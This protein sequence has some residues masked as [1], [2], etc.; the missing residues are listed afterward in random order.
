MIGAPPSPTLSSVS[1]SPQAGGFVSWHPGQVKPTSELQAASKPAS[2]NGRWSQL[3]ASEGLCAL[4]IA[5][6]VFLQAPWVRLS[7]FSA[8]AFTG[9]LVVAGLILERSAQQER[10]RIGSLLVG[11]S[12]SWLAGAI[13]WG[14]LRQH[15]LLHL[16]VEAFALPLALAGSS[17]RWRLACGFYLGSLLGTAATDLAIAATGLMP[18]WPQVLEAGRA[19]AALLLHQ[20]GLRVLEPMGLVMVAAMAVALVQLSRW[21]RRR[22]E[23]GRVAGT[24]LLT[25]LAVDG[26][27]LLAVL[28]APR[29]SGLI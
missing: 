21:L 10:Q 17:G 18:L 8:A 19:D 20:A 25:T 6:P 12:G 26:L 15:P 14:W 9:L 11:F 5:L 22:G 4:L 7:P 1:S 29:M 13:F 16:P 28:L 23:A 24:A 27:F 3:T 2:S